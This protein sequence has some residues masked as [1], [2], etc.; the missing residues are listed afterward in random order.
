MKK[1]VIG[2]I[3]GA[4]I[5][6]VPALAVTLQSYQANV[7]DYPILLNY[8]SMELESPMFNVEGRTYIPLREFCEYADVNISWNEGAHYAKVSLPY[9]LEKDIDT[10]TKPWLSDNYLE[11]TFNERYPAVPDERAAANLAACMWRN[12]YNANVGKP[13]QVE[14]IEEHDLWAVATTPVDGELGG[15]FLATIRRTTGEV[16]NLDMMR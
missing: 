2:F 11:K 14:Y 9:I 3:L 1:F 12:Y 16:V 5:C 15:V 7:V 4:V 10:Q 8:R 6:G 13:V